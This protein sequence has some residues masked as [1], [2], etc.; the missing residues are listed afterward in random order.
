MN[1]AITSIATVL[2]G[3]T[4]PLH[5]DPTSWTAGPFDMPDSAI[6]DATYD[7]IVVSVIHG[8]PGEAD[9]YGHLV[10]LFPDGE[11]LVPSWITGLYAPKGMAIV[12]EK[13]LV[14][15][16]TRLPEIDLP[17]GTLL[18]SFEVNVAVFLYDISSNGEQTY[19]SDFMGNRAGNIRQAT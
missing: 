12:R 16:L 18:R 19:V 14:A 17:T 8:H 4:S 1:H 6:F 13:L 7:C 9:G 2:I 10:Q 5:A 3:L 11:I 15:D